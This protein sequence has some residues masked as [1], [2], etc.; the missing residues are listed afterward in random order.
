MAEEKIGVVTHYFG[1]IQVAAI[2]LESELKVGDVVHISGHTSDFTETI[3]SM[4]LEHDSIE[5]GKKGDE[6]AIRVS[7]HAREGDVVFKV[8]P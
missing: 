4:Q 7:E 3:E 8:T 1:H 2:K 5:A 6:I